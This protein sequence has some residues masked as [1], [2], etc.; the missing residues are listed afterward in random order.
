MTIVAPINWSGIGQP[1]SMERVEHA[2]LQAVSDIDCDCLSFSGGIDSCLLLYLMQKLGKSVRTFTI[3]CSPDHPDVEYSHRAISFFKALLHTDI[4]ESH[5]FVRPNLTGDD[6]V[7]SFYSIISQHTVSIIT[8]DGIDELMCGYYDHQKSPTEDV[9]FDRLHRLVP[10]HLQPLDKNSGS[11]KVYL[12][13]LDERVTRLL[14]Q[15]PLSEKVD[16]NE[17]KKLML[18]LAKGKIPEEIIERR[19]YGFG[20]TP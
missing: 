16:T 6:L 17:R 2:M 15:I 3:T 10:E 8:G 13:Y 1:V 11:V 7:A 20:T 19:K 5:W 9:Y 4:R 14:W 18:K 12:P